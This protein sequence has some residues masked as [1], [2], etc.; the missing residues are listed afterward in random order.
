MRRLLLPVLLLCLPLWAHARFDGPRTV[1][2]R[3][4]QRSEARLTVYANGRA[5]VQERFDVVL[6]DAESRLRFHGLP[7]ALDRGS[8]SLTG[9]ELVV[10]SLT[11]EADLLTPRRLLQAHLGELVR[12]IRIDPATGAE[13]A[14]AAEILSVADGLVVRIGGRIVSNPEGQ[15]VFSRITEGVRGR[16]ILS[17]RVRSAAIGRSQLLNLS[18]LTGGLGWRAEYT[19]HLDASASRLRLTAWASVE[20]SSHHDFGTVRLALVAGEIQDAGPATGTRYARMAMAAPPAPESL[21]GAYR[22]YRFDDPWTLGPR[23]TVRMPLIETREVP[24]HQRYV[25]SGGAQPYVGRRPDSAREHATLRIDFR[26]DRA[27]NL[28]IPLPAGILYVYTERQGGAGELLG[29]DRIPAAPEEAKVRL[30]LGRAFDVWAERRQ[31]DYRVEK[32]P[33]PQRR[34]YTTRHEIRLHNGLDGPV[35]AWVEESIPG[36]WTI[37]DES[38][39]HTRLNAHT[40][41][42]AVDIPSAGERSLSYTVRVLQ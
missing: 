19:G 25:F 29:I 23:T 16:P 12:I 9:P 6:H 8:V 42:W 4:T 35:I 38:V 30:T 10:E 2:L 24:V 41:R 14:Q 1:D 7:P 36:D 27:S 5:L 28:G 17:A 39:E 34:R 40:V 11:Y 13:I 22:I 3:P 18:Y 20:N 26:N 32:A 15:I 21:A 37:L 33:P 31:T